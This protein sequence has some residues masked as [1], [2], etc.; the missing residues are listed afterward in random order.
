MEV[1]KELNEWLAANMPDNGHSLLSPSGYNGW[2]KCTGGMLG[3][4]KARAN[5][6][7]NI[8]SVEGTL[9]H[10]LLEIC[11]LYWISPKLLRQT[12]ND[13][14]SEGWKWSQRIVNNKNNSDEVKEFAKKC[15][16]ELATCDFSD[17]MR[18]E[19]DKCYQRILVYKMDGWEVLAESKVSLEAYFGHKHCD[20]TSDVIMWK[21][22][23]IMI[24]DLKYGKGIEVSPVNNGQLKLYCGG[25]LAMLWQRIGFVASRITLVIMQPRINNGVWK[26]WETSYD[27]LYQFLME[28]RDLSIQAL[29]VLAGLMPV[30][31]EPNEKSCMWCHRRKGENMCSARQDHA[32]ELAKKA[33]KDAGFVEGGSINPKVISSE[34]LAAIMLRTP[35]I[36]TFLNDV[37]TE[38]QDR[39]RRGTTIPGNKIVKGRAAR[40]WK[41]K[42]ANTLVNTFA[43]AGIT[44]VDC[45]NITLKSPPQMAKLT[46]N[47]DQKKILKDAT[48]FTHGSNILV[49]DTDKREAVGN[50]ASAKF[51]AAGF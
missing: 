2:S 8:A 32:L 37:A 17:E 14:I 47:K 13:I 42:Q 5:D 36:I 22:S 40:A 9:G 28:T 16:I 11:V 49:P 34:V 29:M 27:Q 48:L 50:D 30:K 23:H 41:E 1:S 43:Q 39:A 7:D 19:I 25:G 20:G 18:T 3:L 38:A 46:L 10:F 26:V 31:Y 6:K 44:P 15:Q 45:Y 21:G 33:F 51:K 35:F 4:D 12:P 24:V